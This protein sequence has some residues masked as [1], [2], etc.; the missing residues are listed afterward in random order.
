MW[1][2]STCKLGWEVHGIFPQ[3]YDGTDI[4][5]VCANENRSLVVAGDDFGSI[6]VYRFPVLK[7]S[8]NCRRYAG[9]SEHVPRVRFYEAD[10]LNN[11]IISAGGNDRTYIQ[12]K[13]VE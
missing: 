1:A 12:W 2:T 7:N 6:Q 3:G 4:N 8:A 11:Y 5:H 10:E 13:E 9:H